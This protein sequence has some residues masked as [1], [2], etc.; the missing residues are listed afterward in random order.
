MKAKD[1]GY[2]AVSA[3]LLTVSAWLA[4]PIGTIPVTLQTATLFLMAGLL[5]WKRAVLATLAY[6]L[7]GGIGIPVFAGFTGGFSVLLSPTGGY[8]V[9]FLAISLIVGLYSEKKKSD[10]PW[11]L[12]I[13]MFCGLLVCYGV[14]T[15]WFMVIS[16]AEAGFFGAVV[17]CVLPYLPFDVLKLF[18]SLFLIQKLKKI[19]KM[20]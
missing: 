16:G 19:I 20:T 18:L 3:A 4:V 2:I 15:L 17:L 11:G 7:L 5:G 10:K 13:A 1:L 12:A 6:M 14:G 9:G 8:I